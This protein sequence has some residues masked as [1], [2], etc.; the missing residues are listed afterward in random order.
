MSIKVD[1]SIKD[2]GCV[3]VSYFDMGTGIKID[4]SGIMLSDFIEGVLIDELGKG[5]KYIIDRE[6]IKMWV[7][8]G[9]YKIENGE[10]KYVMS[11][12]GVKVGLKRLYEMVGRLRNKKVEYE[13]SIETDRVAMD[14]IRYI[15]GGIEKGVCIKRGYFPCE[16]AEEHTKS[17]G[18]E[19]QIAKYVIID[20]IGWKFYYGKGKEYESCRENR[21]GER[22]ELILGMIKGLIR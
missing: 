18:E 8:N 1:W 21:M 12:S 7:E 5:K 14:S 16:E 15:V 6:G 17:D 9:L 2:S 4:I 13:W 20:E 3:L 11:F 22:W 19:I 10:N